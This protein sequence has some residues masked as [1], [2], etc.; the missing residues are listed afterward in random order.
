M[1]YAFGRHDRPVRRVSVRFDNGRVVH[2]V[3]NRG[4][5]RAPTDETVSPADPP[6][7][8][9]IIMIDWSRQRADLANLVDGCRIAPRGFRVSMGTRK[10]SGECRKRSASL[11]RT[12]PQHGEC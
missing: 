3:D 9:T 4:D 2:Y 1:A 12:G 6:G 11:R 8:R 10:V 5:M 7:P